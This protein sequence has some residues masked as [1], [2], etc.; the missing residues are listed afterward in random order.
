MTT[1]I[2]A[3]FP[4][5]SHWKYILKNCSWDIDSFYKKQTLRNRTY[6]HGA[7]GLLMLT[8][9]IKHIRTG[10]KKN[11]KEIEIEND[12]GWKKNHFKSIKIA[13]QSS[14]YYEFYESHLI[15]LFNKDFKKLV[16]LN[17]ASI[18]LISKCLNL[19][20]KNR[21]LKINSRIN[22]SYFEITDTKRSKEKNKKY[23]QTFQKKNGFIYDLSVLDLLFNCGPQSFDFL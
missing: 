20:L 8:V 2:P 9:P 10:K 6:I 3:Y 23:I 4:P 18:E 7:N 22:N 19:E 5:I 15:E 17:L 11:F 21:V 13:Y 12:H 14:P 1:L 16:N